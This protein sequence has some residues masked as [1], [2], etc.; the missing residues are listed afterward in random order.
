MAARVGA[1]LAV[2]ALLTASCIF[3]PP[4]ASQSTSPSS[5]ASSLAAPT[6]SATVAT[7]P[8][9]DLRVTPSG[10]VHGDHA[11]VV[12]LNSSATGAPSGVAIWDAPLDGSPA[13]QLVE[14][15][16]GPRI[17]ADYDVMALTRQLS[18][19]GRRLV[20]SDPLDAD[21]GL[22]VV[23][24]IAGT[25]RRIP[26]VAGGGLVG[27]S[28][29]P[30]WS[31]DGRRIAYRGAIASGV[32]PKDTGVWVVSEAGGDARQVVASELSSGA[33]SIYGWTDDGEGI[34]YAQRPDM[35]SIANVSTGA[36]AHIGGQTTGVSPVAVR[37][38][39]PSVA[40]VFNDQ[41]PRG[42]MIGH[43]EV[44][45]TVTGAGKVVARYGPA[46]G[47]F[48]NEPR[49]RPGSDEILVFYAFGQG[50]Q[51]RHE[52]VIADGVTGAR[53]TIATPSYVRSAS[54]SADGK[55]IIYANLEE[56]RIRD[57][58]GSNDHVLF[59]PSNSSRNETSLVVG[60][61]AFAHK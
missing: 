6:P 33:T 20:L 8:F 23:D 39:S 35:L 61:A 41:V 46:E 45:E 11:L 26:L 43:V 4:T 19:D 14:Y 24:L 38:K 49:W 9:R 32:L 52:L 25:A 50:V 30:A 56:V 53:R 18:P 36:V 13:R 40:I 29:Q 17:F 42:P 48:L 27:G 12:Q 31:P 34:I 57:T 47:T 10:N 60:L 55:Q 1:S 51:E 58:D 5:S 16:R 3:A 7:S 37:A 59:R 54:W 28:G 21:G 22:I 15:T 44:R 2:L